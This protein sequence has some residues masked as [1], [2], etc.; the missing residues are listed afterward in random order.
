MR[1]QN[2]AFL[3]FL[4]LIAQQSIAQDIT[5]YLSLEEKWQLDSLSRNAETEFRILPY[6]PIYILL[7]N[8]TTDVNE[9][10]YSS[11]P[12]NVV[13]LAIP[14]N[15]VELVFQLSFKTKILHNI[16][17]PDLGGDVWGAYTQSSRWQVYNN[18]LSRPFRE[19][20]YQP[21]IFLLFGTPYH[22]GNFQ[23]VFT[24]FG[25]THQSNGRANPLSRSWNRMVFQF[26]WEINDLQ[27]VFNPWIRFPEDT[28]KDN[29]PDIENYMGRGELT[30]NYSKGKSEFR[31][32]LRHS[33]RGGD[34]SHAGG[35]LDYSYR[36][37]KNLKA[38]A[39]IFSGYGES[40]IDYNHNQTTFGLGLS[41]Y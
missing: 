39:Q 14:Y 37:Y 8:Y 22:I 26:G 19:T 28:D 40:M 17:G 33:L 29:N 18:E 31:L 3:V 16:L 4:L 11:N 21:E 9:T 20:D 12:E 25:F 35:R 38:H 10:P 24:G 15:P 6:Q 1:Y 36:F 2:L 34:N 41:L 30:L 7:A 13:D 32:A 27:I 5:K 23:G